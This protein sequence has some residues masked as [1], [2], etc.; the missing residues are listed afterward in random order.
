MIYA[1]VN[2]FSSKEE[3]ELQQQFKQPKTLEAQSK[4][5]LN[6]TLFG[7]NQGEK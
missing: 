7:I 6:Q 5:G 3:A 2:H 4:P 1:A